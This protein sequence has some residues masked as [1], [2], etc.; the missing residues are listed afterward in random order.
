MSDPLGLAVLSRVAEED[1]LPFVKALAGIAAIDDEV[2]LDEKKAVMS[3]A[4]AWN[5]N[6]ADVGATRDILRQ[7]TSVSM[8]DLVSAFNQPNTPY[9]LL[10]EL[11]RLSHA[12]GTY[13]AAEK[14]EVERIAHTVGLSDALDDIEAFVERGLVWGTDGEDSSHHDALKDVLNRDDDGEEYS[15]SDIPT[16]DPEEIDRLVGEEDEEDA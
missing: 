7:G 3:F 6:D 11:V 5:L 16:A 12:D 10:E 2:T 9:L 4:K 8:E 15:L 1:R 13:A 14:E